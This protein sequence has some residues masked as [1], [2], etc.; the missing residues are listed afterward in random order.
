MKRT[1]LL[2]A[3]IAIA[4]TV[5]AQSYLGKTLKQTKADLDKKEIYYKDFINTS[6]LL[7]IKYDVSMNERRVYIFDYNQICIEYIISFDNADAVYDYGVAFSKLGFKMVSPNDLEE[8]IMWKMYKGNV[9]AICLKID[10]SEDTG[11]LYKYNVLVEQ[12]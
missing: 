11:D 10:V 1:L 6:N 5:N 8:N 3:L 2:I 9:E 7:A 12:R 4:I